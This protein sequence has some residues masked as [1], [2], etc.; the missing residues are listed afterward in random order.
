M[1]AVVDEHLEAAGR[2]RSRAA[3]AA[4]GRGRRAPRRRARRRGS[5]RAG[6]R[7]APARSFSTI[8]R[9]P[10][11]SAIRG[12]V[13]DAAAG[14]ALADV[15][16]QVVGA[17]RIGRRAAL[18]STTYGSVAGDRRSP[19]SD[20]IAL[21][22][23]RG[24]QAA[25]PRTS[26]TFSESAPRRIDAQWSRRALP[27]LGRV[28]RLAGADRRLDGG[29]R[30][31]LQQGAG[32]G[33]GQ[34]RA[35]VGQVGPA[36]DDRVDGGLGGGEVAA[37]GEQQAAGCERGAG[38]G[39][40]VGGVRRALEGSDDDRRVGAGGDDL[41]AAPGELAR[42]RV[43]A[44][45]QGDATR[46]GGARSSRRARWRRRPP[47]AAARA[48]RGRRWRAASGR[49]RSGAHAATSSRAVA[50]TVGTAPP[51]AP[52]AAGAGARAP[53]R[54]NSRSRHFAAKAALARA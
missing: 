43:V 54:A 35:Q 34:Q 28:V 2:R 15:G 8:V 13:D 52:Q 36:P 17:A 41:D 49:C 12:S 6:C 16:A 40:D 5:R 33:R 7:T 18:A 24:H 27:Q 14:E 37:L 47:G 21:R 29:E 20:V 10:R 44:A 32:A 51:Q 38:A 42:Q 50:G 53:R 39:G 1:D 25:L 31:A 19:T 30:R 45:E 23:R 9:L 22:R 26:S 11:G 48:R 46:S 4:G 3:R